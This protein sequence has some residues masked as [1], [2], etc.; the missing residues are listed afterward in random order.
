M[1]PW[2]LSWKINTP[3]VSCSEEQD[4]SSPFCES[5]SDRMAKGQMVSLCRRRGGIQWPGNQWGS[6]IFLK[7]W[8]KAECILFYFSVFLLLVL[9]IFVSKRHGLFQEPSIEIP[10]DPQAASS[11]DPPC[12]L[13]PQSPWWHDMTWCFLVTTFIYIYIPQDIGTIDMALP[14]PPSPPAS[15]SSSS[16][17]PPPPPQSSPSSS[18]AAVA[19]TSSYIIV[20]S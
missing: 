2:T 18:E 11:V 9:C 15:S 1:W 7:L 3:G 5:H 12:P 14:S 13:P 20:K 6:D 10:F 16:S 8:R 19:A 4:L 17:S